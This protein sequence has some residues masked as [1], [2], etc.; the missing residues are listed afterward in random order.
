MILIDDGFDDDDDGD[1]DDD[2]GS[3]ETCS[4]FNVYCY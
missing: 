3:D 2:C 4:L 1:E